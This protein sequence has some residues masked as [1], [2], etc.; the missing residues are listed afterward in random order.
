MAVYKRTWKRPDG[1]T[2]SCWYFHK[3]INGVRWRDRIPTARTKA[4][5]EEAERQIL[6]EIHAGTYGKPQGNML[7]K[8]FVERVFVPWSR[9]N[10]DSWRSDLSRLKP[11]LDFFGK[12]RLKEICDNPFLV[13]SY[14]ARRLK[15][16]VVYK[17]KGEQSVRKRTDQK[18]RSIES[19]NSCHGYSLW[20]WSEK[21]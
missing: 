3:T 19:F 9:E 14:K 10:K 18:R 5:A 16:P 7:L 8:E 20:R 17:S 21:K 12:K 11:I 6:A 1:S 4:Q 13:E 15:T 2:A